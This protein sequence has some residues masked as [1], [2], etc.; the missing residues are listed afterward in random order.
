MRY[1]IGVD[2]PDRACR[3]QERELGVEQRARL[4]DLAGLDQGADPDRRGEDLGT[5]AAHRSASAA[6][7]RSRAAPRSSHRGA[8]TRRRDTADIAPGPAPRRRATTSSASSSTRSASPT[9]IA[10][11]IAAD[12]VSERN[13]NHSTITSTRP[14]PI[15]AQ[16]AASVSAVSASTMYAIVIVSGMNQLAISDHTSP[17]VPLNP[18]GARAVTSTGPAGD[19][20]SASRISSACS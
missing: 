13:M 9:A 11:A 6:R 12:C 16:P 2:A 19:A 7:H 20:R 10:R 3:R 18:T 15:H 4:R 1:V 17:R 5:A 14:K 8:R